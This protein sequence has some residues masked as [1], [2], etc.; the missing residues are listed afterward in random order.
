[1]HDVRAIGLLAALSARLAGPLVVYG[2]IGELRGTGA[3]IGEPGTPNWNPARQRTVIEYLVDVGA[4]PNAA[5]L[6]GVTALHRAVRNR[7]SAAV[8][9]LLRAGADPRAANGHGST[10]SDLARWTT[11]RGGVGSEAAKTEQRIIIDL[12]RRAT[13]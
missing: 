5:A 6:G 3:V 2:Q 8:E 12:L 9:A 7:C 1:L 4:N 11:G 10:P 13:G